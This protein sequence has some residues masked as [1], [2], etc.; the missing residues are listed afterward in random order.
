MVFVRPQNPILGFLFDALALFGWFLGSLR[1][2]FRGRHVKWLEAEVARLTG[3]N[4]ALWESVWTQQGHGRPNL[5]P[6]GLHQSNA[7]PMP[8][9]AD[10]PGSVAPKQTQPRH[11]GK[12]SWP[13]MQAQLAKDARERMVKE[14]EEAVAAQMARLPPA[15][16]NGA[17]QGE[18]TVNGEHHAT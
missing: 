9:A 4:R 17:G 15:A 14:A 8:Q 12:R 18:P 16:V 13:Q 1:Q 6:I 10:A 11:N 7:S 3:E 2:S 5:P